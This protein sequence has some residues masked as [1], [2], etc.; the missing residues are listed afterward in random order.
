M[1]RGRDFARMWVVEIWRRGDGEG[2]KVIAVGA[3]L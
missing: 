2:S 1:T 3:D